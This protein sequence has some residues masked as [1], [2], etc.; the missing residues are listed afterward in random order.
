MNKQQLAKEK[1]KE[2][3][4][5]IIQENHDHPMKVIRP[6]CNDCQHRIPRTSKCKLLYPNGIP[7]EIFVENPNCEE[8]KQK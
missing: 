4:K 2:M 3:F 8:F 6:K 5:E 7:D 1:I